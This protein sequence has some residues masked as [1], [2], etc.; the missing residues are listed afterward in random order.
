V[1]RKLYYEEGDQFAR[2][3]DDV[4]NGIGVTVKKPRF[5]S[6]ESLSEAFSSNMSYDTGFLPEGTIRYMRRGPRACIAM[7]RPPV[8]ARVSVRIKNVDEMKIVSENLYF[9]EAAVLLSGNA[10]GAVIKMDYRGP[11][12]FALGPE[13]LAGPSYYFPFMNL[14]EGGEV[15]T[16]TSPNLLQFKNWRDTGRYYSIY[17]ASNSNT[18]L[19]PVLKE[20]LDTMGLVRA[21]SVEGGCYKI[22]LKKADS[23]ESDIGNAM[24]MM[25]RGEHN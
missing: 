7:L 25:L 14:Y 10:S 20:S 15:C 6:L 4:Q 21:L 24:E 22:M 18:D 5:I 13:G 1:V 17:L 12:I 2:V 16:G 3:T 9:P 19:P 11:R 8:R 23:A